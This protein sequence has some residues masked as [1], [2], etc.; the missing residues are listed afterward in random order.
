MCLYNIC[1]TLNTQTVPLHEDQ[2]S[3]KVIEMSPNY[4]LQQARIERHWTEQYIADQLGV[5]WQTIALWEQGTASPDASSCLQLCALFGKTAQELGL[6]RLNTSSSSSPRWFIPFLRNPFFT[7]RDTYLCALHEYFQLPNPNPNGKTQARIQILSGIGGIGKTQVALE[8]VYRFCSDY[9]AI[10]WLRMDTSEMLHADLIA[11]TDVFDLPETQGCE[12]HQALSVVKRWLK[13]QSNWLLILDNVEDVDVVCELL[14][15]SYEGY[16]LLTTHC[17]GISIP[18]HCLHLQSWSTEEGTL[19]LL[20]RARILSL[21]APLEVVEDEYRKQA[22]AICQELGGLPLALDQAGA[23]LEETGCT[24]LGYQQRLQD[25]QM[26]LLSRRGSENFAHP[27]PITTTILQ[28]VE[29]IEQESPAAAELLCLCAFLASDTI[30]EA[31][32]TR[33]SAEILGPVLYSSTTNPCAMDTLYTILHATSLVE[34]DMHARLLTIHRLVQMLV[35]THMD[36]ETRQQWARRA[37]LAVNQAFPVTGKEKNPADLSW[38]DQL[39]PHALLTLT[40]IDR[41]LS[42][43]QLFTV[44]PEISSLLLKVGSHLVSRGYYQK[45]QP[46]LERCLS[47]HEQTFGATHPVMA[48]LLTRLG[49][50]LRVQGLH[51]SAEVLLRRALTLYE[52]AALSASPFLSS[53]LTNL[54]IISLDRGYYEQAESLMKRVILI[55]EQLRD[56][57]SIGTSLTDLAIIYRRQGRYQ[58]AKALLLHTLRLCEQASGPENPELLLVLNNLANFY[59]EQGRCEEAEPFRLR[60]LSLSEQMQK[61]EAPQIAMVLLSLGDFSRKQEQYEGAEAQYRQALDLWVQTAGA[62]H[63][64]TAYALHGLALLR[65]AQHRQEEAEQF[66]LATIRIREQAHDEAHADLAEALHDLALL[67]SNQGKAEA[68]WQLFIR[69]VHIRE[70]VLG[71]KHPALA[72]SLHHL[73]LLYARQG[74]K[75]QAQLYYQQALSL[76]KQIF[77]ERH[78]ETRATQDCLNMLG[79]NE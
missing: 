18:G 41:F 79:D 27:E 50:L 4:V 1:G 62:D 23:Y 9:D 51:I 28:A 53:V 76:R 21:H 15:P 46:L 67:Y 16:V 57:E 54:A 5:P 56:S 11:L 45:A 42:E 68:A 19:F 61:L 39:L 29:R 34:L 13:E 31:L 55:Q 38:S 66:F 47:L 70:Q 40:E 48:E 64:L 65:V 33:Q 74:R 30:P 26:Q 63:L 37:L 25:R 73:G 8:Y 36:K 44:A 2:M 52:Q 77:G 17:Q 7:G 20:H 60:A 72:S 49:H 3:G 59:M 78:P 12:Y 69:A 14:P 6:S 10:L 35:L 58:E 43:E 22:A 71:P 32:I 24:L 75:T